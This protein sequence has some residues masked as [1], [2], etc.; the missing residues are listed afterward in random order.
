M[1]R[2]TNDKKM[3]NQYVNLYS[4]LGQNTHETQNGLFVNR[5]FIVIDFTFVG[6]I[7]VRGKLGRKLV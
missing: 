5:V 7:D 6:R 1:M 2:I 4:L 3:K